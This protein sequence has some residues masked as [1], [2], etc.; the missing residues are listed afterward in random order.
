ML[1][2]EDYANPWLATRWTVFW[3]ALMLQEAG[4]DLSLA[5]RAYNVGIGNATGG[6]GAAAV[7]SSARTDRRLGR[8]SAT[9]GARPSGTDDRK[10]A[11]TGYCVLQLFVHKLYR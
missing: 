11:S 5:V 6:D 1:A 8:S 7:T 9:S 3:F 2:D 4:G 10:I